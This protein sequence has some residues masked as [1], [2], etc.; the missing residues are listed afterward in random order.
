MIHCNLTLASWQ[1]AGCKKKYKKGKLLH[2]P[3]NRKNSAV[4]RTDKLGPSAA[5]RIYKLGTSIANRI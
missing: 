5:N 1:L 2:L 3:M 4:D